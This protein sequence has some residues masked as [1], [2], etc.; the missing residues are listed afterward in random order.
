MSS[1][2]ELEALKAQLE[3]MKSQIE[4]MEARPL[5]EANYGKPKFKPSV[6]A[7]FHGRKDKKALELWLFS[8][9]QYVV[10]K[11]LTDDEQVLFATTYM[12]GYAGSWWMDFLQKWN[13]DHEDEM[14]TWEY[15]KQAAMQEFSKINE[16]WRV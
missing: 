3:N 16:T 7:E 2:S 4:L 15:F 14:M 6:P 9:E 5:V 1:P 13:Q 11:S 10:M 12:R 8:I